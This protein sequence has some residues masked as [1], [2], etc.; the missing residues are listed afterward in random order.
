METAMVASD[1]RRQRDSMTRANG[2][3]IALASLG[4]VVVPRGEAAGSAVL[5]QRTALALQAHAST[6]PK[7]V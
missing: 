6:F 4:A 5:H 3:G 2:S 7:V 1:E